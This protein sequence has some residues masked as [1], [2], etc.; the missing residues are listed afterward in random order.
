MVHLST[1]IVFATLTATLVPV[2]A[3][4]VS[5]SDNLEARHYS[6]YVETFHL[7][8]LLRL[9]V[10]YLATKLGVPLTI[11]GL[12]ITR[13]ARRKVTQQRKL[14]RPPPLVDNFTFFA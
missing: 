6:V 2:I 11:S 1:S 13:L 8:S 5:L 3:V 14:V 12:V 7:F 9:V 10:L 4:P